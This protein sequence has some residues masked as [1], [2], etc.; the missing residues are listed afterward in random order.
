MK[1]SKAL[2]FEIF[3]LFY[4]LISWSTYVNLF[5]LNSIIVYFSITI[6]LITYYAVLDG[7]NKKGYLILSFICLA[8]IVIVAFGKNEIQLI[9]RNLWFPLSVFVVY[10]IKK[11]VS[12]NFFRKSL[13]LILIIYVLSAIDFLYAFGGNNH[14]EVIR[15]VGREYNHIYK[16]LFTITNSRIGDIIRVAGI[17]DEPGALVFVQWLVVLTN[18]YKKNHKLINTI[19]ILSLLTFSV[20]NLIIL[21]VYYGGISIRNKKSIYKIIAVALLGIILIQNYSNLKDFEFIINRFEI[22]NG[23][24]AG[25][26]RSKQI[27]NF[28]NR[29]D[30]N[31]FMFGQSVNK[32]NEVDVSSSFVTPIYYNGILISWPYYVLLLLLFYYTLKYR[33]EKYLILLLLLLQRPYL[34]EMGYSLLI[35]M[36]FLNLKK[37]KFY[38]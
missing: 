20:A 33:N 15:N 27:E 36:T 5:L 37:R 11:N 34:M 13:I 17:Y 23:E 1:Y 3:I 12:E 10:Y 9:N 38:D 2:N 8:S 24:L 14:T 16:Y 22:E 32:V 26:N 30:A 31:I 4:V 29:V 6:L 7:E 28:L 21:V 18:S 19:N 25:D 35:V